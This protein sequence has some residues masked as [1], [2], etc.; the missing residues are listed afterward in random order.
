MK[1]LRLLSAVFSCTII[2][3]PLQSLADDKY[4]ACRSDSWD[5]SSCWNPTGQPMDGDDVYLTQSDSTDRVVTYANAITPTP[6]L[7]SLNVDATGSGTMTLSQSQ[8]SLFSLD[9]SIQNGIYNLGGT[10]F[11]RT[12][13]SLIGAWPPFGEPRI[14][15][16]A[17]FN[18]SGGNFDAIDDLFIGSNGTYNLNGGNVGSGFQLVVYGTF[19]QSNGTHA[20]ADSSNVYGTYNLSGGKFI[21]NNGSKAVT[22]TFNQTG[23]EHTVSVSDV[24]SYDV[25]GTYN[26]SGGTTIIIN[27]TYPDMR[28]ALDLHAGGT[29][30]LSGGL[31]D[32]DNIE[33]SDGKFNFTGGTLTVDEFIGDLDNKGGT[34]S[35]GNSPGTTH[36]TGNYSQT[37]D[38][39]YA[40]EIGGS[41]TGEFDV[42]DVEGTATL[43]GFLDVSL[44]DLG[45]GEFLPSL[46]DSFDILLAQMIS[47]RFD[48]YSLPMINENFS[49]NVSYLTDEIGSTDVVRL[50]VKAPEPTTITLLSIGLIGMG[51]ARC[52]KR[53]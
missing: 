45:S 32:A 49:W 6:S 13:Y 10:G 41:G 31:L 52:K 12:T 14:G 33:V 20:N 37:H 47:G 38:S 17:V 53:T 3:N 30:N 4:W 40:V 1:T 48:D 11:L 22:G 35:P 24:G 36:I 43:S 19:N 50:S 46:G 34:L 9:L 15:T 8:D 44:I 29:Y 39:V 51:F 26:Q 21:D 42:L 27:R 23:G 18:Q 25:Y 5:Q 28:H 7:I 16:S 2:L